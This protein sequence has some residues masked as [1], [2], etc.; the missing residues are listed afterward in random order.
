MEA[1]ADGFRGDFELRPGGGAAGVQFAK[2]FLYEV[3]RCSSGV[4]LEVSACAITLDSVAP[5]GNLP[6]ELNLRKKRGLGK[7]DLDAVAGRLYVIDI[8]Q[9]GESGRPETS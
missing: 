6:L 8:H 7:I 1:A 9:T 3:Q 5:L 2:G 4:R